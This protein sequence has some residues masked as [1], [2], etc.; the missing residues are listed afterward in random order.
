MKFATT[1]LSIFFTAG[2]ANAALRGDGNN[3][4]PSRR[5][6][7]APGTECVTYMR[8]TMNEDETNDH[9]WSCEFSSEDAVQFGGERMVDI[10][11]LTLEDIND[12]HAI[13]GGTVLK[14]GAS[15]YVETTD[16]GNILH[17]DTSDS[18]V[19]EEMDEEIDVRHYKNRKQRRRRLSAPDSTGNLKTLVMRLIDSEGAEPP[20]AQKLEDDVWKDDACLKSAYEECSYNEITIEQPDEAGFSA[21]YNNVEYK[22]IID[23]QMEGKAGDESDKY[24][25]WKKGV[26]LAETA[27]GVGEGGIENMFDLVMVCYPPGVQS[28]WIAY[29]Y[30]NHH[31]S[32]YNNDWCSYLSA[33]MHEV[34]HNIGL[35][36][37]GENG[38]EYGDQTGAMAYG[39]SSDDTPLVCFNAAKSYQLGW[40]T[41]HVTTIDPLNLPGGV[42]TLVLNGVVNYGNGG[43]VSVRLESNGDVEG[44]VDYYIGYNRATDFNVGTG[45]GADQV[46]VVE[47]V[48][49]GYGRN[50]YGQSWLKAK[51]SATDSYTLDI[52]G[53]D[54]TITVDSIVGADAIVTITGDGPPVS[55]PT[56]VPSGSPT[57][58]PSAAPTRAPVDPT[59]A[60]SVS[61]TE[62]PSAAPTRA[63]IDPTE[64]PSVS[65]TEAPSAAPSAAPVDPTEAPSVS[66]TE[67]PSVAPSTSPVAPTS[68]PEP[69]PLPTKS[70]KKTKA[71]KRKLRS[72]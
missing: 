67:A 38:D 16:T 54:V 6:H 4:N 59:E 31:V 33:Q 20:N 64:A 68:S 24:E 30:I 63:P 71:P 17:V 56:D 7:L 1:A 51:L 52:D 43:F 66:P 23:V 50:G 32:V 35:A 29:A 39:F 37:S 47:K 14:V 42:Q 46:H 65:P 5:R 69:T 8:I 28:G 62:A 34:G 18:F 27:T 70:G 58:A 72:N 49:E 13:S 25:F 36:H 57:E 41:N 26:T 45:E 22:G 60:P 55:N 9:A 12:R 10:D 11:G 61:P 19:I 2:F 3:A 40:Y 48:N 21:T 15:S 44:G 53:T